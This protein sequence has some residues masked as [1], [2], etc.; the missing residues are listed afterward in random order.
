MH[1]VVVLAV[2]AVLLSGCAEQPKPPVPLTEAEIDVFYQRNDDVLWSTYDVGD[3]P[4]PEVIHAHVPPSLRGPAMLQCLL[5]L[6]YGGAYGVSN[7]RVMIS[8]PPPTGAKAVAAFACEARY[9]SEPSEVGYYS[10]SELGYAY[11]YIENWLIPC[12]ALA[13]YPIEVLE[14]RDAFAPGPGYL[15]WNPYYELDAPSEG[16]RDALLKRCPPLPD[17]FDWNPADFGGT[18]D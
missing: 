10:A 12:L 17:Y 11:D 5:D 13:G 3:T 15:Q 1:R 6:G 2:A 7:G 18:A 14:P 16:E 9:E 8:G 4:R